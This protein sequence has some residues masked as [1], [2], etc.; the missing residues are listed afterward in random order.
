MNDKR[1]KLDIQDLIPVGLV[2]VVAGILLAF[3]AQVTGDIRDDQGLEDCAG[4][5]DTY[6][7]Y[8]AT[9]D[10]CYNS[11]GTHVEVGTHNFNITTASLESSWNLANRMPTI[12]LVAAIVIVIGLLV[13]GFGYLM[14]RR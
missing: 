11:S 12:G 14:G 6:T 10:Q 5:S 7:S 8:N 3:G 9:S 4:R 13:S 2:L 1:A